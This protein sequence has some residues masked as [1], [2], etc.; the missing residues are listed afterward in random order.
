MY[1]P[2]LFFRLS[3]IQVIYFLPLCTLDRYKPKLDFPDWSLCRVSCIK[4]YRNLLSR[5]GDEISGRTDR[6]SSAL[7]VYF[8][9]LEQRTLI[10]WWR[11]GINSESKSYVNIEEDKNDE[12]LR[13]SRSR[14]EQVT[15]ENSAWIWRKKSRRKSLWSDIKER[16]VCYLVWRHFLSS[17]YF[18]TLIFYRVI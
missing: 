12:I 15:W 9:Y 14:G 8:I 18:S 7:F 11:W 3:H 10:K 2:I 1:V 6:Q 16:W 5:L 17:T 13:W 4:S